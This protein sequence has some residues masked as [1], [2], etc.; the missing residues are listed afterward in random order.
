M[1]SLIIILLL[2][3]TSFVFLTYHKNKYKS[4][5]D[6]NNT[7]LEHYTNPQIDS[8]DI[9]THMDYIHRLLEG[10]SIKHW[11]T[12]STLLGAVRDKNIIEQDNH[13]YFGANYADTETIV[14]LNDYISSSG[15]TLYKPTNL[16]WDYLSLTKSFKL[17]TSTIK[18]KYNGLDVGTIY[19]YY[20]FP[21]EI[22]RVMDIANQVYYW[23][24]LSFPSWYIE[25]LSATT[26]GNKSYPAPR[27]AEILLKYWYG[28]DWKTPNITHININDHYDKQLDISKIIQYDLAYYLDKTYSITV[29]P[30]LN[31]T[32]R[33]I[34]PKEQKIWL[35]ANDPPYQP[36]VVSQSRV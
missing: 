30:Y 15:Y 36:K 29:R 18:V 20:K 32:V 10:F 24:I 5:D 13:F 31:N 4:S 27:N 17:W 7:S 21:D 22:M 26:I 11:L 3:I 28:K 2:L 16:V 33:Y 19:L 9:F 25:E 1:N 34:A 6:N 14:N 12:L 35:A 23:P 8:S